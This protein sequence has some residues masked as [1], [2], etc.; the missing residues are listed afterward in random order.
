M[1]AGTRHPSLWLLTPAADRMFRKAKER[2][3]RMEHSL[4]GNGSGGGQLVTVLEENPKWKL[5]RQVLHEIR[6]DY[7]NNNE[8]TD[9][10]TTALVMVQDDRTLQ[11]LKSYLTGGK[12]ET[13]ALTWLRFL[14]H[15]NDRSRSILGQEGL[16]S[17]SE[18]RRLLYEE[19][20]RTRQILFGDKKKSNTKSNNKNSTTQQKRKAPKLNQV[21]AYLKKR[22]RVANEMGRGDLTHQRDDLEREAILD[23]AVEEVEQ[24]FH[25]MNSSSSPDDAA[26]ARQRTRLGD[27]LKLARQ[28]DQEADE[29]MFRVS[30]PTELRVLIRSYD[31]VECDYT[32]L[33]QDL[34]PRYIVFYDVDVSFIRSVEMFAAL[35]STKTIPDIKSYFLIFD[36]S[37]EE[38]TFMKALEK[39]QQAFERLVQHKMTMP[40]PLLHD[41]T[42]TQEIQ[43]AVAQG[44]ASSTYLDGTLPL[45]FDSSTT[46]TTR[47]GQGKAVDK[48]RRDI[49]VDVREFRAALPSILHQGGMRL[50]PVTLTVGDFVL[51]NVHCVE[52][53]SISDL[54]GSFGS[55]RL[56]DQ[57][58]AMCKFYKE[59]PCLLIEFDPSKSFCLQN[60]NE[61]GVDIRQDAI[62]SKMVILII[63][64]PLLRILW[65]KT[66][67]ETLKIFADLKKN[68]KEVDVAKAVAMGR[69]ESLEAL[70]QGPNVGSSSGDSDDD[71]EDE[72]NEA[73]R[74]MLL[75]LPGVT[76]EAARRIMEQVDTLADLAD[77]S[78][79]E[80]RR[81]AG[82]VAGQKLFTFFRQQHNSSE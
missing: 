26:T 1:N 46:A 73:A 59:A 64:N 51:S 8:M 49:A 75:R 42:T 25:Q 10:P 47:K 81:I 16:A 27:R 9:G 14:E 67:H 35:R 72:V 31:S 66:P 39:E 55:G 52:R 70:L 15:K 34:Q 45:A 23:E 24:D 44:S 21:P 13:L 33:L 74:D 69:N 5:V 53:K 62:C 40:P 6:Q 58:Q 4:K 2:V 29:A 32:L 19:E 43:Q 80:M 7:D 41:T 78:R 54:Y 11:S 76:L 30:N 28:H 48:R 3:Y 61:L 18:E 20:G 82:P 79:E 65:S 63:N 36:A 22:R 38:K 50:A 60:P 77:L 56:N 68:H 57:A 71:E 37:A 12:K 17:L